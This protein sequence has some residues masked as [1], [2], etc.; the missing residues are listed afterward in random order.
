M[1]HVNVNV[2]DSTGQ[3]T[4]SGNLSIVG[5]SVVVHSSGDGSNF[6]CGTIQL[7]KQ[8]D[9]TGIKLN[10]ILIRMSSIRVPS[11]THSIF[12]Q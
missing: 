8:T 4:L 2:T 1:P 3:L 5:R 12:S 11:H 10:F 6:E 7:V 9:D